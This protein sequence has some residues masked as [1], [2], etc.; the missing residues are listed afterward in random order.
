MDPLVSPD[1]IAKTDSKDGRQPWQPLGYEKIDA[2]DAE[3]AH[4]FP[5]TFDGTIYS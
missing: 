3:A 1:D 5:G 2:A 4:G